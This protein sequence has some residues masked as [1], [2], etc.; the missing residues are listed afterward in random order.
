MTHDIIILSGIL[1]TLL[2]IYCSIPYLQAILKGRTKP[3]QFSWLIFVIMNGIVTVSQYLKGGRASVLISLTFF[4]FSFVIF[5]LSLKYGSR[6]TSRFDKLLFGFSLATIA[7]WFLTKDATVAIWL[8][9][10][11]DIAAT[12]M[13][14]LKVKNNPKSEDPYPW[15]LGALAYVFTCTAL[16]DKPFG[17][18]YVRPIYGLLSDAAITASVYWY[19]HSR[20]QHLRRHKAEDITPGME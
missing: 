13:I 19:D 7:V 6:D 16:L 9:V 10:V 14:I 8:T 5:L 3:H 1:S 4:I 2:A 12:S 11:I 20:L 15:L 17:V 18:L